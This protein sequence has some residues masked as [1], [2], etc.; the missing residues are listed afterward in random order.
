MLEG[1]PLHV[2][3]HMSL[4]GRPLSG[5]R[6]DDY[7]D[8]LMHDLDVDQDGSVSQDE[9]RRS[10]LYTYNRRRDII[11]NPLLQSLRAQTTATRSDLV[12]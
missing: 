5:V 3:L 8:Q 7:I 10:P 2:R 4:G 1:G 9:R 12:Q 6:S 11:D